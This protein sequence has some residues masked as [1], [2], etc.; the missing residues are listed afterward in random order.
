[1]PDTPPTTDR[2]IMHM[3]CS[4]SFEDPRDTL[5]DG[6]CAGGNCFLHGHQWP[7]YFG[8]LLSY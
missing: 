8:R 3:P 4:C 1:M 6:Y 5:K 7:A 2:R